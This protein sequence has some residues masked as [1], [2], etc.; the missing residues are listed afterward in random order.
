MVITSRGRSRAASPPSAST[1]AA[2]HSYVSIARANSSSTPGRSTL[3]A[4]DRPRSEEHT[5][6]LQSLM[7]ISYAAFCLKKIIR[8]LLL[9]I[10]HHLH[11]L[12]THHPNHTL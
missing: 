4:T 1:W 9:S 10:I 2:A 3:T 11:S 6:E 5:S 7:R 8:I 12:Y